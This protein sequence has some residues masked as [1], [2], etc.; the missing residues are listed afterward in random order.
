[1][2]YLFKNP[3]WINTLLSEVNVVDD[4]P[5][6]IFDEI[7]VGLDYFCHPR[8]LVSVVIPAFNE[9]TSIV[10]TLYSLSKNK[11]SFPAEIIVVNN[12]STDRTQSVL[13][14]LHVRSFQQTKQGCGPS[15]Q[16]GQQM[17][18]GKYILMGDADCLYPERWIEKM[19]RELMKPSV[20]CVYGRYSFLGTSDKPRWQLFIYEFLRDVIHEVRNIKRPYLN[21]L[22]MSMGYIKD[23]GLKKGFVDRK[24]RGEDGRMCFDLMSYGKVK[25][26]RSYANSVWT[27][28][29]T[30]DKE[31]SLV[32]SV[33]ARFSLEMA[34][35][36]DYFVQQ[37][38]HDTHTSEN[39]DP[40]SIH[41]LSKFK[42][43]H[44]QKED[45]QKKEDVKP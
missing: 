16:L 17:A 40:K 31:G 36:K 11:T 34:R 1:M 23:L 22:G 3:A 20:T 32:Y 44:K 21:A 28:P 13:D 39:F 45:V 18:K 41:Y 42:N 8:P 4:I 6:S 19:T 33:F 9:E 38:A 5:Q 12:N 7:N 15:R 43:V 24:I 27:L 10:R 25:R 2:I 14:R 35:F 29:R 37:K 30:L 26:V